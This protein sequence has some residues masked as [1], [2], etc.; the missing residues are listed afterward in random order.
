MKTREG[1]FGEEKSLTS[2]FHA[3]SFAMENFLARKRDTCNL[4]SE[5]SSPRVFMQIQTISTK[6]S[7]TT[8]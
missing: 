3:N 1:Q 6:E 8:I 5:T 2:R 7:S 4:E